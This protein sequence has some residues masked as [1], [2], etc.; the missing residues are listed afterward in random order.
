MASAGSDADVRF[1]PGTVERTAKILVVGSFGVGKTT[2][3][4]AVSEIEPLRTEEPLTT[5]SVGVDDLR[6]LPGKTTTTVALDFGRVSLS[7]RL[8]LYLFGT[9]GQRRFWDMWAGLAEGAVG[10]LV[11]VDVRRLADSFEVLDHLEDA[12]LA[13][14]AVAVNRFPDSPEHDPAALREAL[15]LLPET[16][17]LS[18]D[19]RD[20]DSA[21]AALVRLVEYVLTRKPS[22]PA[23]GMRP[24][25]LR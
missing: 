20:R 18:C 13:A 24:G 23:T 25:D 8:V 15:D 3:V 1:V 6:G 10:V 4:G 14:F 5:A 2:F 12:G 11:L 7:E 17:V 21:V 16:P 9:P 22:M 19:A